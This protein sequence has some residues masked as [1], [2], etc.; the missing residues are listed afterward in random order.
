[1]I[2]PSQIMDIS[3]FDSKLKNVLLNISFSKGK[4]ARKKLLM[5]KTDV[6]TLKEK[7]MKDWILLTKL[8]RS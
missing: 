1:L 7:K 2:L 3:A 8:V 5:R 6:K 4:L